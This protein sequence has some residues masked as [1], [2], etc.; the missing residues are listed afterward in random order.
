MEPLERL[1]NVSEILFETDDEKSLN[2][3]LDL[4][5]RCAITSPAFDEVRSEK[6]GDL[7]ST[8]Q[9][10]RYAVNVMAMSPQTLKG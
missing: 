9:K 4:I 6:R 8:Y 5:F 7:F 2:E 10:I 1:N 3:D